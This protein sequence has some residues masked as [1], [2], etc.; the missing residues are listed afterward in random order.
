M[1]AFRALVIPRDLLYFGGEDKSD[2][3][4]RH[5]DKYAHHAEPFHPRE[6]IYN[7]DSENKRKKKH[8]KRRHTY[9][10]LEAKHTSIVSLLFFKKL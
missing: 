6:S 4:D 7:N 8:K 2:D 1:R 9:Y 5:S 3:R 10:D